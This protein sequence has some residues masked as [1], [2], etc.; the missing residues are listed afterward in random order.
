[1][2][3]QQVVSLVQVTIVT[4]SYKSTNYLTALPAAYIN[5]DLKN[6]CPK[7]VMFLIP[8]KMDLSN[9]YTKAL[10]F[11]FLSVAEGVAL[12]QHAPLTEL[13]DVADQL[14]QKQVGHGKVT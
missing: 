14:R 5:I 7:F 10:Q 4:H 11:E 8:Q 3:Q 1:M 12:F 6:S 9:L 13:M 2:M